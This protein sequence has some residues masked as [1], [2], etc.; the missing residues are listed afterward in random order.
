MELGMSQ[1]ELAEAVGYTGR[2]AIARIESGRN[3][4]SLNKI[5]LFAKA[6]RTTR[7]YILG[8]DE[9]PDIYDEQRILQSYRNASEEGKAMFRKLA[10]LYL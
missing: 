8:V 2:S 1:E 5:P 3:K 7:A 4:V 10:E 6:L 9:S